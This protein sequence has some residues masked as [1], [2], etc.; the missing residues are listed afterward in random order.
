MTDEQIDEMAEQ[1]FDMTID[2]RGRKA[3]DADDNGV[4][5]FARHR[6]MR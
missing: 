3:Y 2:V 5:A 6:R 1:M 4:I